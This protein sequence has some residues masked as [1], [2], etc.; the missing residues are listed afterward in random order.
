M[1][2]SR[3][4]DGRRNPYEGPFNSPQAVQGQTQVVSRSMPQRQTES[5][6]RS[7]RHLSP[8]EDLWKFNFKASPVS[9]P[10]VHTPKS[11]KG[12]SEE[13]ANN[14]IAAS[15]SRSTCKKRKRQRG[16]EGKAGA[17]FVPLRVNMLHR[18]HRHRTP[19]PVVQTI[20]GEGGGDNRKAVFEQSSESPLTSVIPDWASGEGG[21]CEE[22]DRCGD[23]SGGVGLVCEPE[24]GMVSS[25][26]FFCIRVSTLNAASLFL[27]LCE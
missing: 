26:S 8:E 7:G 17:D 10:L 9:S 27:F 16:G 22:D 12:E 13:H 14:S 20:H 23:E 18:R 1:A 6:S 19:T 11:H 2:V 24:H 3:R 21:R 15:S 25:A 4:H 5:R